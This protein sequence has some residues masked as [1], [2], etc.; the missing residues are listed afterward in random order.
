M[1]GAGDSVHGGRPSAAGLLAAE[2]PAAAVREAGG[3]GGEGADAAGAVRGAAY[4]A[5]LAVGDR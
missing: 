2:Q 5:A 4:A 3:E 1:P